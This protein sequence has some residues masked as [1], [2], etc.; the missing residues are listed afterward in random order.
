M[1]RIYRYRKHIR[2]GQYAISLASTAV[3]ITFCV[4]CLG[5][6]L[7]VEYPFNLIFLA[8]GVV[9]PLIFLSV[10][11]ACWYLYY[12]LAGIEVSI[13]DDAVIYKTRSGVSTLP[14]EEISCLE[15]PSIKYTGGW[16]RI[17]TPRNS[18]RLTVVVEGI[19]Q[20]L[21]ELKAALDA[22]GLSDLYDRGKLFQF[23]K[24][25]AFSDQSWVRVYRVWWGLILISIISAAWGYMCASIAEL[26]TGG[27]LIPVTFW[28]ASIIPFLGADLYFGRYFAKTADEESFSYPAS[29]PAFENRIYLKAVM[30]WGL[31]CLMVLA[32]AVILRL[33]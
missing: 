33:L 14:L 32:G 3:A 1:T 23:L 31:F 2:W 17:V 8:F 19:D 22:H 16:L 18:I 11:G 9:F 15:F 7:N 5:L 25:A 6:A 24:T 13:Q 20:F 21:L 10:G 4:F 26:G 28:G 30:L 27:L 12:R 29:D